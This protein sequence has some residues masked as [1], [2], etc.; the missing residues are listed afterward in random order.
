MQR[1]LILLVHLCHVAMVTAVDGCHKDW[2]KDHRPR[3]NCTAAG[4]SDIPVGFEPTTKVLLFPRNLFSTLTWTSFQ[5]FKEIYEIDL[6]GNKIPEVTPS[7]GPILPSL[8]VL[9]LGLNRLT[10]LSDGSFSACP[11]LTELYL[12]NNAINSLSDHTFSG[13]SKL[14]ILDLSANRIK[15]LPKLMLHPLRV[16]ETLY[17]E[18]NKIKVMP[19]DW[20]S[21]KEEV[22][23]LYLSDNP[24]ACSCSL[25]YLRR[26]LDDYELNVYV[27]DGPIIRSDA[28]SVVCDSPQSLKSKPV[29]SLEEFD[30]CSLPTEP[31]PEGDFYEPVPTS[32][33]YYINTL[34]PDTLHIT[35]PPPPT[36]PPLPPTTTSL[37]PTAPPLPPTT[38]TTMLAVTRLV[39]HRV[40]TWSWYQTFTSF[41]EWSEVRE[42]IIG[43]SHHVLPTV[44]PTT[45]SPPYMTTTAPTEL[46]P[47]TVMSRKQKVQVVTAPFTTEETSTP[48][49]SWEIGTVVG[50]RTQ[51]VGAAR[52]FCFWLFAGCLLLCLALAAC[53]LTTL[54]RLI[55]WYRGVYKPLSVVVSRRGGGREGVRLVTYTRREEKDVAG[56]EGGVKALYRSVLYVHREEGEAEGREAGGKESEGGR[57][58]LLVNLAPTGGG[59]GA[60]REDGETVRR[61]EGAVYRK[62]LY[63]VLSKEEEIEGWRDVMEECR[64]PAQEGER[65]PR[66]KDGERSGGL[67]SRKRYS[68][69]LREEREEVD[70]GKE[71]LDW[72][73][74]GWEVKRG[75]GA[76][77]EEPRSSW[78][79][80]LAQYLPS[81]PWGVTPP[82]EGEA[83]Q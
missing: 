40:V 56:G 67:G 66:G 64:L 2:D 25:G 23:Y 32:H 80:W 5:P 17:L 30:L 34:I 75:E 62:T 59:G 68:L 41:I 79:E 10:S 33:H 21:Q 77:E 58:S 39:Y 81:M 48:T 29:L 18:S 26:Y 50:G 46:R 54:A 36:A 42:G 4:Y 7:A 52:V 22:P 82:P 14:E 76:K 6:T 8:S 74:G 83:A 49:T 69:I 60:T 27:R 51:A 65:R 53:I 57:E 1:F 12:D 35:A 73:V 38:T 24:W 13:L 37:P 20:F 9:R 78:G 16:I 63:R 11:D 28:E 55:V 19:D 61:E 72:V 43:G 71:E 44:S 47:S 70:G 31:G 45:Q 15:E 3:E